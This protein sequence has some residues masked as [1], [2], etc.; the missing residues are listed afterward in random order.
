[1]SHTQVQWGRG[2][3]AQIA[4]YTGPQGEIVVSTDDYSLSVQDGATAGGATRLTP[5]LPTPRGRLTLV[6]ATPVMTA[7]VTA[8]TLIYYT[9]HQGSH[10]PLHNG[11][12]WTAQAFTEF[13]LALDGNSG[14]AG[15]HQ[16]G[17]L[18]DLLVFNNGGSLALGTGPIWSSSTARGSGAGTTELQMLN[19]IWTNKNAITLRFGSSSGNTVSVAANQA[20]YVGTFYATADG[21]TGM[22]FKP[23]AAAGGSNSFLGLYNA[24]NRVRILTRSADSATNWSYTTAAWRAANN[25][26]SNRVNWVDGL[27]Q[28]W[29]FASY[30][31]IISGAAQ[32]S[33]GVT[34]DG[35]GAPPGLQGYFNGTLSSVRANDQM[36]GLG[37]HFAQAM[38]SGN[39]GLTFFAGSGIY[40]K[41]EAQLEM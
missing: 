14:H 12:V 33:I 27:A 3:S 41:L 22:Q 34:F 18:F 15:Y 17:K 16:S 36:I 7:D 8:A 31:D 20:T 25:S 1:L 38:E 6:S 11:T 13:S 30:D 26:N 21:Q 40:G 29:V 32:G 4:A 10:L 19:G 35:T 37:L 39:T 23:S 28:S 24:Y 9:P 5:S 2:T